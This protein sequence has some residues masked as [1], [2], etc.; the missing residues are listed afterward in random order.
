MKRSIFNRPTYEEA[1]AKKI[2]SDEKKRNKPATAKEKKGDWWKQKSAELKSLAKQ[3]KAWKLAV[4]RRDN[5]TCQYPGC[6]FKHVYI[7]CHHKAPRSQRKDLE[8]VVT[9]GVAVCDKHHKWAHNNHSKAEALGLFS[10]RSRELATKEE[11][12][13]V[14]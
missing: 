3:E 2:A 8:W 14:Y 4:R 1:L 9:N 7:P 6:K 5:Y 12:L 11:T 13:G 10:T